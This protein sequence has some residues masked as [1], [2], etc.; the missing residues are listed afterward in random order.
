MKP[1]KA[2]FTVS[3]LAF[4][5]GL[6]TAAK[7][8]EEIALS[9]DL[10][11]IAKDNVVE[12]SPEAIAPEPPPETLV[13]A[14]APLPVPPGAEN[15]PLSGDTSWPAGV[16]GGVDAIAMGSVQSVQELLP[17]PPTV[18]AE[19]AAAL[20]P[21]VPEEVLTEQA[22]AVAA[23][24]T[25]DE[26]IDRLI[27]FTLDLDS[28]HIA[29]PKAEATLAEAAPETQTPAITPA[30]DAIEAIF[31]GGT[32][33]LVARAVGSA[34]GT[35]TPEGHKNPAYFGHVDPGNGVWN[36]GTFSYQH[37]AQTPEEA[38]DK[39]LKRLKSQTSILKQKAQ[40]HGLELSQEEL[41]NGI[42]LANQAPLAALDRGGYI[43]WLREAHS[44]GMHGSEAIIWARTRSFID[45]DTQTWNAPGLGNN[46]YT[47]SND[48]ERRAT[49]IARAIA[50]TDPA[51]PT[52]SPLPT[53]NPVVVAV[54]QQTTT[55]TQALSNA[56]DDLALSFFGEN[57]SQVKESSLASAVPE[58]LDQAQPET[59]L[60][61]GDAETASALPETPESKP[62]EGDSAEVG[63]LLS[64]S[65]TPSH[66]AEAS[67]HQKKSASQTKDDAV[68]TG[69]RDLQPAVVS[70]DSVVTLDETPSAE[71]LT[72]TVNRF[73]ENAVSAKSTAARGELD[74][75][76]QMVTTEQEQGIDSTDISAASAQTLAP[77]VEIT[78]EPDFSATASTTATPTAA[79]A[80]VSLASSPPGFSTP[81]I[82]KPIRKAISDRSES[83]NSQLTKDAPAPK[84]DAPKDAT[85]QLIESLE[86]FQKNLRAE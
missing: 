81:R 28:R 4:T 15:P 12:P 36:M 38:D 55:A 27:A 6:G 43:D 63:D 32:D 65:E 83:E 52:S 9:F 73:E 84:A 80:A 85:S 58:N 48:Q 64:M 50:A 11:P 51:I 75:L 72:G 76:S 42:D 35:R 86:Q 1:Y 8:E 13:N 25:V 10:Q 41:L 30:F 21:P 7:A 22:V 5:L 33:S 68:R 37:G 70:S 3:T 59:A 61:N 14:E 29:E 16:Y 49:A 20:A 53:A 44:L 46:V 79:S 67:N 24:A 47:I 40:A 77:E 39:Q 71:L 31:N 62:I 82:F 56:A 23:A 34:E 74:E 45:P 17:A 66:L 2:L 78:T 54:E 18:P 69:E 19:V 57:A 60:V 26:K